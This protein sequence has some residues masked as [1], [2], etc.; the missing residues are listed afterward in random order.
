MWCTTCQNTVGRPPYEGGCGCWLVEC[1]K[2][3]TPE[4]QLFK[5]W[6]GLPHHITKISIVL[7]LLLN[8]ACSRL[9]RMGGGINYRENI[10]TFIPRNQWSIKSM[11]QLLISVKFGYQ[12]TYRTH[13][14]GFDFELIKHRL[15]FPSKLHNWYATLRRFRWII[16]FLAFG[17]KRNL[18]SKL[19][20]RSSS[21][22]NL[23]EI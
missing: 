10:L 2:Y 19:G 15:V 22:F 3:S 16:V 14:S 13:F 5:P 6:P 17:N 11:L 23:G 21:W 1:S 8:L 7:F 20:N 9:G 12:L 4:G 18:K